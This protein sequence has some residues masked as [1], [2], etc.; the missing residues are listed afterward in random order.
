M[1]R[2]FA[3]GSPPPITIGALTRSKASMARGSVSSFEPSL[4]Q[5]TSNCG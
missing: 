5:I 2:T 1:A 3:V 4:Q